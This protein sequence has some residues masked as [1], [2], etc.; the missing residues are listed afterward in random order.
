MF[1]LHTAVNVISPEQANDRLLLNGLGG[2]DTIDA[3]SL[4]TDGMQPTMNGG[5]GVDVLL[6][7]DG[8]DVILG[9]AI[10]VIDGR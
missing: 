9:G 1:G 8:D 5:L 4:E 7:G 6:G 10:D 3:T 2:D